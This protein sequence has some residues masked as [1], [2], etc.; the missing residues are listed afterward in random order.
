MAAL[1]DGMAA[2]GALFK[3]GDGGGTEVF[4]TLAEVISISGPGLSLDTI[5]ITN[6]SS[7][8][9]WKEYV[10]SLIDGGEVTLDLNYVP[11]D[12][13]QRF[14]TSGLGFD[15]KSKT[16]RNFQLYWP[17]NPTGTGT[18]WSLS[19]YVTKWQPGAPVGDKLSAAVT[20]KLTGVPTLA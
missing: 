10:P 4:T 15:M 17:D 12:V 8:S 7:P 6:H 13:T 14:T 1:T 11:T 16:K 9:A 19:G 18:L 20:I 3:V 5:D 2:F